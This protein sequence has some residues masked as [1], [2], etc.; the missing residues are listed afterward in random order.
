MTSL[1]QSHSETQHHHQPTLQQQQ[2]HRTTTTPNTN[3]DGWILYYSPEGFPYYYNEITGESQWAENEQEMSEV[4]DHHDH[5]TYKYDTQNEEYGVRQ[6]LSDV[7]SEAEDDDEDVEG[8]DSDDHDDDDSATTGTEA[9][10]S[11]T[12]GTEDD[13]FNE[14]FEAYLKSPEGQQE[15]E[16][17]TLTCKTQWLCL[18]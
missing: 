6:P 7:S 18:R 15:L 10:T 9:S 5:D 8:S 11:A 14:D 17:C 12:T 16:V 4:E 2:S 1:Y 3:T 13:G